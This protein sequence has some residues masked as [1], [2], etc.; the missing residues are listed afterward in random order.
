VIDAVHAPII[1]GHPV[2]QLDSSML[3]DKNVNSFLIPLAWSVVETADGIFDWTTL[4][5]L[6]AQAAGVNKTVVLD[7]MPGWDSPSWLYAAGARSFNFLW[8]QKNWG[9]GLCTIATIPVPWDTIYMQKWSALINALGAR[10]STNKT[11]IGV[12]LT[13]ISS[14]S[15]ETNLPH[16]VNKKISDG[17]TNCTGYDYVI[18]W[19]AAGYNRTL[20]ES[21][22]LAFAQ[23]YE[24]AFPTAA[25]ISVMQPEGFPPI[26]QLGNIFSSRTG[27]DPIATSDILATGVADFPGQF[28]IQN[29]ALASTWIWPLE[30]S[31][32]SQA[33]TGYQTLSALGATLPAAM[34]L[35]T[36]GGADY[37]ELYEADL[38]NPS[39]MKNIGAAQAK[40]LLN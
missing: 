14:E 40:L 9:P 3:T 26:D 19:Q 32:A 10:Y 22:W 33:I 5:S 35:A 28:G 24:Q 17:T 27:G 7:I 6:I 36:A 20:I 4:D 16:S 21:T 30:E 12:K 13:G 8:D 37:L 38:L 18:N 1:R 2:I 25:L 11:V 15:A 34:I 23:A 31:Y 39:L 29:S